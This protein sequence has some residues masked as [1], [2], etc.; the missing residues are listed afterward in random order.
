MNKFFAPSI[1]QKIRLK[2]GFKFA[3]IEK[4][5]GGH[6]LIRFGNNARKW[7]R[8]HQIGVNVP[9]GWKNFRALVDGEKSFSDF[10]ADGFVNHFQ[11][12]YVEG[13][14]IFIVLT[15]LLTIAA[16]IIKNCV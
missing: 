8:V 2:G 9:R 4:I 7:D 13:L 6:M 5:E 11:S 12:I 15:G 14:M 1:G 16:L 10:V 3:T